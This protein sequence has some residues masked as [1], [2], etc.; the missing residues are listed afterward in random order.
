M[1]AVQVVI[2]WVVAG[3][4]FAPV[5]PKMSF[6]DMRD[7]NFVLWELLFLVAVQVAGPSFKS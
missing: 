5:G 6:F 1:L 3:E 4:Y 7:E 2:F